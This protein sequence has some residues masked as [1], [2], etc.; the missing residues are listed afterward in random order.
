[1]RNPYGFLNH[2]GHLGSP[3]GSSPSG[4]DLRGGR[5]LPRGRSGGGGGAGRERPP[6]ATAPGGGGDGG[7]GVGS[8]PYL[9]VSTQIRMVSPPRRC[10][11]PPGGCGA[12]GECLGRGE[13]ERGAVEMGEME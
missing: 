2:P 7:G 5:V 8:M 3:P 12:R 11:A 4:R 13:T 10:P 9:L 1:M 6:P